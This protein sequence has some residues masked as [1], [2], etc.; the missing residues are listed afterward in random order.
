M[1]K[2][3]YLILS[4]YTFCAIAHTTT[5][6]RIRCKDASGNYSLKADLVVDSLSEPYETNGSFDIVGNAYG[7]YEKYYCG[8]GSSYSRE[9]IED[10]HYLELRLSRIDYSN[11]DDLSLKDYNKFKRLLKENIII[12]L[13]IQR[14]FNITKFTASSYN[15]VFLDY[16]MSGGVELSF[17]IYSFIETESFIP[18]LLALESKFP[19]L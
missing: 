19:N 18:M 5:Y 6:R 14:R 3:I 17:D 4:I 2:V 16:P 7:I 10:S 8:K 9:I 1:N 15:F 11:V 13:N 12:F